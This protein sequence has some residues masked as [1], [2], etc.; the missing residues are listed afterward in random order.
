MSIRQCKR[1]HTNRECMD[2]IYWLDSQFAKPDR[3]DYYM[4]RIAYEISQF[5]SDL[6][7]TSF[8][9]ELDDFIIPFGKKEVVQEQPVELTVEERTA[10]EKAFAGLYF[11]PHMR[12][13]NVSSH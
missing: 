3:H 5:R 1:E 4:M 7:Q 11:K 12:K 10:R 6:G 8:D 2:W 9:K 13:E